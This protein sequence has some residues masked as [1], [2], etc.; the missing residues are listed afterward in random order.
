MTNY[1]YY[2]YLTSRICKVQEDK[3][4]YETGKNLKTYFNALCL[5]NGST[6]EGRQKAFQW[7]THHKKFTPIVV[8]HNEIYFP[9]TSKR[10]PQCQWVLY[11]NIEHIHYTKKTCTIYFKD[12]TCLLTSHPKRVHDITT[13]I[14]R[15][16]NYSQPP[17]ESQS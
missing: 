14:W 6:L 11:Q 10:H 9:L 3:K 5:Q 4:E 1:I 15:Y 7:Q 17:H 8:S 2:D 12:H 16:V 13:Q